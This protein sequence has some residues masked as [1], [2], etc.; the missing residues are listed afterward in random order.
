M[1]SSK[2]QKG[3]APIILLF[4]V[5]ALAGLVY[6]IA[7]NRQVNLQSGASNNVQSATGKLVK[8]GSPDF[9]PCGN[10]ASFTYGLLGAQVLAAATTAPVP[11]TGTPRQT[12][13][14]NTIRFP[15]AGKIRIYYFD[16]LNSSPGESFGKMLF[17]LSKG[18]Q[19]TAVTMPGGSLQGT[20]KME[21]KDTGISV[22]AGDTFTVTSYYNNSTKSNVGWIAPTSSKQCGAPGHLA[23]AAPQINYATSF[24][25]QLVS[26]QCWGDQAVPG[27][28]NSTYDFNDFVAIFSYTPSVATPPPTAT[29]ATPIPTPKTSACTPL[30]V[31]ASIADPLVGS[32][33][34]ATGTLKDGIFYATG[35]RLAS[36]T[37]TP[38]P[39]PKSTP[40]PIVCKTGVNTFSVNTPC[41]NNGFRYMY[42]QCHDG[43]VSNQGGPT[44]CKASDIWSAYAK[45]FCAG[46]SNCKTPSPF[47]KTPSPTPKPSTPFPGTPSPRPPTPTATPVSVPLPT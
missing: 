47:P 40:G 36:S 8:K 28:P 16:Y 11:G 18:G 29:P 9:A 12:P 31:Q 15:K 27:D 34:I 30:M 4:L 22:N 45:D 39:T 43:S 5:V 2:L 32:R 41:E 13:S 21:F 24:G 20:A 6:F 33:V 17:K 19:I 38:L 44:S 1:R 7:T 10:G 35:L 14:P 3:F 42:V 46:K 26:Q 23:S 37:P 25:Q